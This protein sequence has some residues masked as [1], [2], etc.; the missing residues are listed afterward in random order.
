MVSREKDN[1]LMVIMKTNKQINKQTEIHTPVL[2]KLENLSVYWQLIISQTL[3]KIFL[4]IMPLK[5]NKVA[6]PLLF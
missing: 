5:S 1:K 6:V 2:V 4:N 3:S